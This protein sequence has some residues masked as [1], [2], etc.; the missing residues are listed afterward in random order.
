MD[1][2][3]KLKAFLEN[4]KRLNKHF[5]ITPLLYGSLGLE[6]VTGAGI[7]VD[8]IDILIPEHHLLDGWNK[9]RRY[10][11]TLGYVLTDEN[12]HTFEKE[13]ISFSYARIEEL[14]SFAGI[15]LDDIK[16]ERRGEVS[17]KILSPEQYLAVYKASSEDGYRLNVK[18]KK[19]N[20]KIE[21]I[22]RFIENR[23]RESAKRKKLKIK[24]FCR[25]TPLATAL[26]AL[27]FAALSL[28]TASAFLHKEYG[29]AIGLS[30][31]LAVAFT[32]L[33]FYFNYGLSV[34]EKHVSIIYFN[35]L[36]FFRYEDVTKIEIWLDYDMITG[37]VKAKKEKEYDFFF[38][39]FNISTRER[40]FRK[41][42]DVKVNL[43]DKEMQNIKNRSLAYEKIK[44][45]LPTERR[46]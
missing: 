11:E 38:G 41:V 29:I 28:I 1:N 33:L 3:I 5:G 13:G 6:Y 15:S 40:F 42:W 24:R 26:F 37:S 4:A 8:D 10:L 30:A 23:N 9:F 36:R 22:N 21:L 45:H 46:K 14:R 31:V 20:E 44:V 35:E 34:S 7:S 16:T 27:L 17:F 43:S 39:D 2:K 25:M 12:E 18:E 32:A 19:D